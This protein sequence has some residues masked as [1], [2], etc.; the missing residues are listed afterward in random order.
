MQAGV[1]LFRQH[2]TRTCVSSAGSLSS[3]EITVEK[4]NVGCLSVVPRFWADGARPGAA[5]GAA[6]EPPTEVVL[7]YPGFVS[8]LHVTMSF[9]TGLTF[10][11]MAPYESLQVRTCFVC[12]YY[13]YLRNYN[14]Y[15]TMVP[16]SCQIVQIRCVPW[17]WSCNDED[18]E[19]NHYP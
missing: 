13:L 7:L 9:P 1:Q 2:G 12:I 16:A 3:R 15:I 5:H 10:P 19:R 6:C 11:L 17:R 14:N 18:L 8:K 4:S